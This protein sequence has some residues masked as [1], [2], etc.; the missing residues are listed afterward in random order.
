VG[1]YYFAIRVM[2]TIP[3]E[4]TIAEF[5]TDSDYKRADTFD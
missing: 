3:E 4:E 1:E 2:E 5:L